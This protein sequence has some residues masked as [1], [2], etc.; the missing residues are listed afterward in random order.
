MKL[1]TKYYTIDILFLIAILLVSCVVMY[2]ILSKVSNYPFTLYNIVLVVLFF[3]NIRY[4]FF[5]KHSILSNRSGL[6]VVIF[7]VYF[8]LAVYITV[9]FQE[10]LPYKDGDAYFQ[11]RFRD[12]YFEDEDFRSRLIDYIEHEMTFF[13]S[14]FLISFVALQIA[15]L[16]QVWLNWINNNSL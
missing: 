10:F 11:M 15:L 6:L 4:A 7:I 16:R 12:L 3:I 5:M 1:F 9:Q 2:P 14:G 8:L 13:Y